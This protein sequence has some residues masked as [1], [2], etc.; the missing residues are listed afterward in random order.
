MSLRFAFAFRLASSA[1]T[2]G[3]S[4]G[5]DK[6]WGRDADSRAASRESL[7]KVE[8]NVLTVGRGATEVV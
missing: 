5:S 7:P 8:R 4:S 2:A 3:G 6:R 1:E